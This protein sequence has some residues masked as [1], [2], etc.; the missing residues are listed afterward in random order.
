MK[1]RK[2]VLLGVL[3]LST[4]GVVLAQ[5]PKYFYCKYCGYKASSVSTLTASACPRHPLGFCKGRHALYEGAE[6]QTYTCKYCGKKSNDLRSLTANKCMRHPDGP[7][8]GNHS[9]AL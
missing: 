9:P 7:A 4:L 5:A 6:K 1:S 2:A 8:K 3:V